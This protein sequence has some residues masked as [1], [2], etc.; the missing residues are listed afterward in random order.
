MSFVQL[1]QEKYTQLLDEYKRVKSQNA[2]L[3][4]ELKQVIFPFPLK[5]EIISSRRTGNIVQGQG[6][7]IQ[8]K[9]GAK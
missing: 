8:R 3:K 2:Q 4:L 7:E 5:L 1:S 6:E 9:N